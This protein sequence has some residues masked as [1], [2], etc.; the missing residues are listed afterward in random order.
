[1]S[2]YNGWTNYETWRVDLE[3]FDGCAASDFL[4]RGRGG[5]SAYIADLSQVLCDHAFEQIE[6]QAQ[7]LALDYARAFLEAVNYREIAEKLLCVDEANGEADEDEADEADEAELL[8][9]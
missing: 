6:E 2:T 1:M 3:M 8:D 4:S 5:R 9:A 7:G